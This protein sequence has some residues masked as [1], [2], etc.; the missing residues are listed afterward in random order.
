MDGEW[1]GVCVLLS[2]SVK[3]KVD[4]GDSAAVGPVV[5]IGTDSEWLD[6]AS[7]DADG[8][9]SCDAVGASERDADC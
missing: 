5:V 3:A 4:E 7:L 9:R 1:G 8:A 6:E 2:V